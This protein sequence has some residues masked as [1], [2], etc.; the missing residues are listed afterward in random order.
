MDRYLVGDPVATDGP[1]AINRPRGDRRSSDA[2]IWPFK[3]HRARQPFDAG[4]GTMIAPVT[5]GEG[6]YWRAF[7]WDQA[8]RL[9][10][11]RAGLEYSGTYGFVDTEMYWPLS[12]MVTPADRALGCT[13]CHGDGGRMDWRALGY[14]GDPMQLGGTR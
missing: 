1:T 4:L 9:G 8:M 12:H 13:D 7:D 14:D 11:A 2:R 3:I 5:S 6:G 10:A